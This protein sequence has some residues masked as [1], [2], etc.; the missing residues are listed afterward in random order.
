MIRSER[1][2]KEGLQRL[3]DEASEISLLERKLRQLQVSESQIENTL[4]A[5][6]ASQ[7]SLAGEVRAFETRANKRDPQSA[8]AGVLAGPNLGRVLV[9]MRIALGMS[10][11][12]LA[13]ALGMPVA[14]LARE[15]RDEYRG[16][17]MLTARRI[18]ETLKTI[19]TRQRALAELV[20]PDPAVRQ[21]H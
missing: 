14:D 9:A 3:T 2:Y 5:R 16:L 18:L 11:R 17:S 19:Q 20:A 21:L 4:A 12:D 10:Q 6:V 1:E 13:D 15:E 8:A 7:R